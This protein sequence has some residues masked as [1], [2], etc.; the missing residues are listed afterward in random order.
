MTHR[1][2][3]RRGDAMV[4][5]LDQWQALS[6]RAGSPNLFY[7][8]WMLQPAVE[9]GLCDAPPEWLIVKEGAQWIALFPLMRSSRRGAQILS[10][11]LHPYCCASTPLL[12]RGHERAAA[13]A[14]FAWL[15]TQRRVLWVDW[16]R[17]PAEG[18]VHAA[19]C[20]AAPSILDRGSTDRALY[21]P[22]PGAPFAAYL[23]DVLATKH[24]QNYRRL[25]KKLGATCEVISDAARGEAW[26]QQF[27]Q[28]ERA[29]WKG[30]EGSAMDCAPATR[31]FFL[32]T[33][34]A[35]LA[36]GRVQLLSLVRDGQPIA[37]KTHLL[38]GAL[39]YT[40]KV[41]FDEAHA[42]QSPGALLELAAMQQLLAIPGVVA[43]DSA[44]VP[45]NEPFD[46]LYNAR[47]PIAQ[48]RL[49]TGGLLSRAALAAL[50]IAAR[51]RPSLR[52]LRQTLSDFRRQ[53]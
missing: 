49:G 12:A 50:P 38:D 37:M 41:A 7:E 17:L 8:P 11:L 52:A 29:G 39:A 2:E 32:R 23:D 40:W 33:L 21:R 43:M 3:H 27:L 48:L 42:K 46:R 31:D 24:Q 30:Q 28:L 15:R 45:K 18:P 4:K 6:A 25:D 19:L 51:A 26:L 34:R 5:D 53:R 1:I 10:P 13:V 36:K 9:L 35:G 22:T 47:R 16:L 44:G 20:E 14:L